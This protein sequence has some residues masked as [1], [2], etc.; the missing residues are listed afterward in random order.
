MYLNKIRKIIKKHTKRKDFFRI[1]GNYYP[2]DSDEFKMIERAYNVAKREFRDVYRDSGDRYFEHLRC[3]ALI[4]LAYLHIRNPVVICAALLHDIDEDIDDW[5][6]YR[7]K[8]EFGEEVAILVW[9]LSKPPLKN[10]GGSKTKRDLRYH[11]NLYLAPRWAIIIKLADRL[12]NLLTIWETDVE[13]RKRKILETVNF[14]PALA[15]KETVLIY[16]LEEVLDELKGE[17]ALPT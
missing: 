10:F 8:A 1:V 11:E 16:E 4:I 13:K 2:P 5:D 9:W 7:V 12:H 3:V 17:V 6:Y 14:F 15:V